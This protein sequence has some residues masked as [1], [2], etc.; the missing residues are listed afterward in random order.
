MHWYKHHSTILASSSTKPSQRRPSLLLLSCHSTAAYISSLCNSD[1]AS[2]DHLH[3]TSSLNSFN[4]SAMSSDTACFAQQDLTIQA[5][6]IHWEAFS[7]AQ[8]FDSM[9]GSHRARLLSISSS[10]AAAWLTITPSVG[11]GFH[12]DPNELHTVVNGELVPL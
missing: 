12:L 7:F 4:L 6:Q 5:S 8:L 1:C 9:P 2:S 11:L 10:H 3:L